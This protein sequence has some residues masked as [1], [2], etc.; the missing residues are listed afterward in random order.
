MS[1]TREGEQMTWEAVF[2]AITLIVGSLGG[3]SV[4]MLAVTKWGSEILTAKIKAD[5]EHKHKKEIAA[6]EKQLS[7]STAKLNTLLQNTSYI[8]QQQYDLEME[9]YKDAWES[10]FDLMLCK[11]WTEDLKVLNPQA[12]NISNENELREQ[13][14]NRYADFVNKLGAYQKIVDA[15]APFYQKDAYLTMKE[16][17]A[18]FQKIESIFAKYKDEIRLADQQD[19]AIMDQTCMEIDR[20]KELLVEE[21]R[22]YLQSLKCI[23]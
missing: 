7:D 18:E 10:L 16:I 13:R 2:Q 17:I 12:S 3:G 6:Y 14:R 23:S 5:I 22:R 4:I 15:N 20:K 9:I 1:G 19:I 8:T 11:Q 21:V